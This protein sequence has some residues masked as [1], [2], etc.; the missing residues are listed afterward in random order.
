MCVI[1][2]WIG[3]FLARGF[4]FTLYFMF[5]ISFYAVSYRVTHVRASSLSFL[6]A[7]YVFF[8]YVNFNVLKYFNVCVS[9]YIVVFMIHV[10]SLNNFDLIF[11][12]C[13]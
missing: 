9:C 7:L 8:C 1:S 13:W 6:A 2:W 12:T 3:F 11:F 5:I 4:V 10:L